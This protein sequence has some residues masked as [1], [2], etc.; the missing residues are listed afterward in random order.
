MFYVANIITLSIFLEVLWKST[1][2]VYYKLYIFWPPLVNQFDIHGLFFGGYTRFILLDKWVFMVIGKPCLLKVCNCHI[3]LYYC[4]H[5]VIN[6]I[7]A[8]LIIISIILIA[9]R[10]YMCFYFFLSGLNYIV[11]LIPKYWRKH[12]T[13]LSCDII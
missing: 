6:F 9:P 12:L 1:L 2:L 8:F 5:C 4:F 7:V 11:S 10:S 3:Q 13:K